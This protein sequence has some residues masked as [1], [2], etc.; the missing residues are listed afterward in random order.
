MNVVDTAILY[1]NVR[2]SRYKHSLKYL[3]KK[4]LGTC[5]QKGSHDSIQDAIATMQL[6]K[7]KFQHGSLRSIFY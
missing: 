7:L 2:G 6:A 3:S 1:P 4:F 5:I